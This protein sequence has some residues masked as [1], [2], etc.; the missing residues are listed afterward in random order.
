VLFG[1]RPA[2]SF[3]VKSAKKIIAF[4]PTATIGTVIIRVYTPVGVSSPSSVDAYTYSAAA[5]GKHKHRR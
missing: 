1:A 2:L 5:A 4:S 3:T